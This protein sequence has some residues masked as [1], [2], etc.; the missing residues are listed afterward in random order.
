MTEFLGRVLG[1]KVYRNQDKY[2]SLNISLQDEG[3][4]Q[5]W[6]FDTGDMVITLLL[7]VP[8]SGGVFEYCPRIR[9]KE[10]ENFDQVRKVLDGKSDQGKTTKSSSGYAQSFSGPL[11]YPSCN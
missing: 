7:Q 5:Q 9:S 2:Q 4:C 1:R 8:E 3:G 11:L 10:D 6:H